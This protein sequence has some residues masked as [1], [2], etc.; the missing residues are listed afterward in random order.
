[1]LY[2]I[3]LDRL[4]SRPDLTVEAFGDD[5]MEEVRAFQR[6]QAALAGSGLIDR[7]DD[8]W[9]HLVLS[10]EESE[11]IHRFLVRRDG[12]ITG[13]LVAFF[14]REKGHLP[15][16]YSVQEVGMQFG[17]SCRD[18]VWT[19]EDSARALL[20]VAAAHRATGTNL[21][22]SGPI[23]DPLQFLLKGPEA[24]VQA[25]YH[26]MERLVNV[27]AALA[28]R[29]YPEGMTESFELGVSDGLVE[30]N[31][32][33]YR[34]DITAGRATVSR[35]PRAEARVDVGALAAMFTGWLR[36]ADAVRLGRLA[37]ASGS[38]VAILERAFSGAPPWMSEHF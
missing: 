18:L 17:I 27:E 23:N 3:P 21:Y 30:E 32:G 8:V 31:S 26:W 7:S 25:A 10:S 14:S 2:S 6:H 33:G 16:F 12:R 24:T 4:E 11:V 9:K 28:A 20:G 37:N 19:D 5:G 1:M 36:P 13:Y 34:V 29:G 38:V 22:W 35:I 15:P